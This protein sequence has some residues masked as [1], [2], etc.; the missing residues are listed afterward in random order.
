MLQCVSPGAVCDGMAGMG[1]IGT[2]L[3]GRVKGLLFHSI[4]GNRRP[5]QIT[6]TLQQDMIIKD[7]S[8]LHR[9]YATNVLC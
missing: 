7:D 6:I 8:H 9:T 2:D 5:C 4:W 3:V 1:Q